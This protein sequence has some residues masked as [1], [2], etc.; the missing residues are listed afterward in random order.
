MYRTIETEIWTDPRFTSLPQNGKLL[1]LYLFSNTHSHLCGLYYLPDAYVVTDTHINQTELDTLWDTLSSAGLI[2]RDRKFHMI[3]VKNMLKRQTGGKK[4]GDKALRS[5][6]N[7]IRTLHKCLIIH[8]FIERYP[9]VKK[10]LKEYPI[11]TLCHTHATVGRQEQEEEQD[12]EEEENT[13]PSACADGV[14]KSESSPRSEPI[15]VYEWLKRKWHELFRE[16]HGSD[17]LWDGGKDGAAFAKILGLC[18][19]KRETAKRGEKMT[20]EQRAEIH[21]DN[22]KPGAL[23]ANIFRAYLDD[24]TPYYTGHPLTLLRSKLQT[25]KIK[26]EGGTLYPDEQP[27]GPAPDPAYVREVVEAIE[28]GKASANG[29]H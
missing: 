23:V 29:S 18:G 25:F 17:Y 21:A 5:A 4:I 19:V 2:W 20:A 27:D 11:D 6:A 3:W 9:Q 7:H 22:R 12:K 26:A 8:E 14:K 10:H 13:L 24:P 28:S 1:F 15:T 16:T